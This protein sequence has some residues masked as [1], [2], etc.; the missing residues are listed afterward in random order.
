[1]KNNFLPEGTIVMMV[2]RESVDFDFGDGE[3]AEGK[4]VWWT[5]LYIWTEKRSHVKFPPPDQIT[6]HFDVIELLHLSFLV[7]GGKALS[8]K[9]LIK[10]IA[11]ITPN[12]FRL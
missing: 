6:T 4:G 8:C 9:N 10:K 7:L 5:I 11:Y 1:M 3:I 12:H 2:K